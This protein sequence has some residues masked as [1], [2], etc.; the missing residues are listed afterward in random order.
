MSSGVN[1]FDL[2]ELKRRGI[3]LGNTPMVLNAAVA[4][5]GILLTLAAS[6]RMHESIIAIKK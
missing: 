3:K 4:D 6:R 5:M 1:Q 2:K